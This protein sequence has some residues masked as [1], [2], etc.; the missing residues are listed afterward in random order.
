MP[1]FAVPFTINEL[2]SKIAHSGDEETDLA[3]LT[4]RTNKD[5]E[6]VEF[7]RENFECEAYNEDGSSKRFMGYHTLPN[8][9]SFIGC[10]AGG[11]WESPVYFIYYWSGKELRAY[12]PSKG[13]TYN[14]EVK[15]A[16]GNEESGDDDPEP[17]FDL[18][19]KDIQ[20]RIVVR[21]K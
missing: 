15:M 7:D 6:K 4:E 9:M 2:K 11:D 18:M 20:E 10:Y 3:Y 12:I 17:D 21:E 1:R 5:L 16:Y 19:L 13:N 8:G 14:E